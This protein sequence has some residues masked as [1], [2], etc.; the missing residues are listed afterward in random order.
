[1][2]EKLKR[3]EVRVVSD[4]EEDSGAEIRARAAML[5]GGS[6]MSDDDKRAVASFIAGG[7][8]LSDALKT[9]GF[10]VDIS[11]RCF[12]E[13]EPLVREE[14][15]AILTVIA[16]D[17]M[18][19]AKDRLA[20]VKQMALM[21]G[22]NEQVIVTETRKGLTTADSDRIKEGILGITNEIP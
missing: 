8:S 18:Y 20:A 2:S 17:P 7:L 21:E 5:A 1:M 12:E 10:E 6:R 16:R 9:C 22:W 13:I 14:C 19:S 3:G 4:P 15:L 11:R